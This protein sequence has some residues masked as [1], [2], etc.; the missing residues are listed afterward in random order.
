MCEG[1]GLNLRLKSHRPW[2]ALI[3]INVHDHFEYLAQA[4]LIPFVRIFDIDI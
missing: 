1:T 4:L 3:L 2:V